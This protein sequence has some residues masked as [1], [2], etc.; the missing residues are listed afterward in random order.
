LQVQD[1]DGRRRVHTFT[2]V[3]LSDIV[4]AAQPRFGNDPFTVAG[5][6]VAVTGVTGAT[7]IVGFPEFVSQFNGKRII[8]AYL[9]D[10]QNLPGPGFA[11]LAVPEDSTRARFLTVAR[12]TVGEPQP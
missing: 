5:K 2:G 4:A 6:Y 8:L 9:L 3:L 7:A 1:A 10:L 12:L 11:M